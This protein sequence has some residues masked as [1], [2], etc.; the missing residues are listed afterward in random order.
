MTCAMIR[1]SS[2]LVAVVIMATSLTTW[3]EEVQMTGKNTP[4]ATIA[5]TTYPG[6][7]R[8]SKI[9]VTVNRYSTT[10]DHP[11]WDETHTTNHAVTIKSGG[12]TRHSGFG[13]RTHSNGD[14]SFY[15]FEGAVDT[16]VNED[17]SWESSWNGTWTS[18]GG[19]GKYANVK[20]SG[21]Y[22]GRATSAGGNE[23]TTWEGTVDF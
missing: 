14:V 16:R 3:G 20:G 9:E 15:S 12:L 1:R 10:S 18:L 22:Q 4:E 8:E 17:K 13:I 2:L 23:G 7:N 19:T 21:T 11:D 5:K 6:P